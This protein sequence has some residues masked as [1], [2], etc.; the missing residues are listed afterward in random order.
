MEVDSWN[1]LKRFL[2]LLLN[3]SCL[4]LNSWS[5]CYNGFLVSVIERSIQPH[6]HSHC[7]DIWYTILTFDYVYVFCEV[8][9]L[10]LWW[11][12]FSQY[13][14]AANGSVGAS[15]HFSA[16][17]SLFQMVLFKCSLEWP[18]QHKISTCKLSKD[19]Y[20]CSLF[21][22]FNHSAPSNIQQPQ[23]SPC[24]E[25][26]SVVIWASIYATVQ[27]IWFGSCL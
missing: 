14:S 4:Y 10:Q 5:V 27:C 2:I 13:Q 15:L 21:N 1:P 3:H 18:P 25:N 6:S 19:S 22:Y 24:C 16:F 8:F 7:R 11:V 23:R 26:W 12:L 9:R 17:F 20:I